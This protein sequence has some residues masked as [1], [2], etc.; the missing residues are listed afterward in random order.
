[1]AIFDPVKNK[2]IKL[3]KR[4]HYK[5]YMHPKVARII[6]NQFH[7]LYYHTPIPPT[8][9]RTT[10]LGTTI[11]KC[12]LDLWIYQEILYELKPDVIIECGTESGGSARYLA[13]LCDLIGHG[14]VVTIDIIDKERPKHER[15][16]YLTGSSTSPEM[17]AK[18]RSLI[19]PDERVLVLLD[20]DHSMQHVLEEMKNFGPFV[21]QGSYM[22]V[23]DSNINGHPVDPL[24]G[25]GP[26]EAI[27]AFMKEDDHFVIDKD[28]EKF[29]LTFNPNGYLKKIK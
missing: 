24:F 6:T 15:V 16:T 1:M 5:F 12:P 7:R 13:C 26:M 3:A 29:F 17:I 28:Q 4:L 8:W 18:V 19:E 20:S 10:W 11:L 23:E 14:R 22:I 2:I 9:T 21:T 25:P 27:W